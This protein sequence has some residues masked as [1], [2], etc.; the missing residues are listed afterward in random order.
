MIHVGFMTAHESAQLIVNDIAPRLRELG[1][2]GFAL[3]CYIQGADDTGDQKTERHLI[4]DGGNDVTVQDGL[5]PM[6]LI[7]GRWKD[8]VL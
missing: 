3:A 6:V 8:G 4:V 1:V 7:G 5:R 2:R